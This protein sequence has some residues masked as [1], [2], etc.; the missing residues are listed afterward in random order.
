MQF[1]TLTLSLFAAIAVASP[2]ASPGLQSESALNTTPGSN[3]AYPS[4]A[5][6]IGECNGT[7]QT[8]TCQSGKFKDCQCGYGCG[9]D[10][11]PCTAGG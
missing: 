8:L 9:K 10:D 2:T 4:G 3:C 7:P 6:N 11:G 5:C 1:A